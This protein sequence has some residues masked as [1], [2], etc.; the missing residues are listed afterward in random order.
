MLRYCEYCNKDYEF[1]PLAVSGSNPLICP[2]CG[3]IVGKNSRNPTKKADAE[4]TDENIGKAIGG[5]AFLQI[6]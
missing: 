3:N 5:M 1:T 2:E 6:I 4:K